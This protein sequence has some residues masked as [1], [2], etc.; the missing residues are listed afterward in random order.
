[1]AQV[2]ISPCLASPSSCT[3]QTCSLESQVE[4]LAADHVCIPDCS[5]SVSEW[6][7]SGFSA[8]LLKFMLSASYCASS[9]D[10]GIGFV[11]R[12]SFSGLQSVFRPS[13][14]FYSCVRCPIPDPIPLCT[15][16]LCRMVNALRA[17]RGARWRVSGYRQ[18]GAHRR[19]HVCHLSRTSRRN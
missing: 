10:H 15:P 9:A 4:G 13:V 16:S 18:K 12:F 14:S 5:P 3:L 17:V 7:Q 11:P 19:V 1:M 6:V 8:N 2:C